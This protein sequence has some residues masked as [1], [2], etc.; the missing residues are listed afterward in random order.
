MTR[1]TEEIAAEQAGAAEG[2]ELTW[3][4]RKKA[5]MNRAEKLAAAFLE[6]LKDGQLIG[7]F[8]KAGAQLQV[9]AAVHEEYEEALTVY[10]QDPLNKEK[11]KRAEELEQ[12]CAETHDYQTLKE[13]GVD[14]QIKYLKALDFVDT[15]G[16]SMRVYN[17][18]R[19]RTGWNDELGVACSCG[20][21]YPNKMWHQ[22]DKNK[23]QWYCRVDWEPLVKEF[24]KHPEDVMLNKL[25]TYLKG[26]YG[27]DRAEW[28]QVGCGARFTPFKKGA[29]MVVEIK[30]A[31]N[32]WTSFVAER[33]PSELDDA[34]KGHRAKFY[35]AQKDLTPEELLDTLPM[36]FPMTHTI[37]EFPGVAQYPVD[38]WERNG[39]PR[40]TVKSWCKLCMKVAAKDL[41]NLSKVFEIAQACEARAPAE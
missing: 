19:A 4:K 27:E 20:L 31:D 18:C 11:K 23:W 35:M 3:S 8:E 36:A 1:A 29:S 15:L 34:I 32:E 2:E 22:P 10:L 16:P 17:V 7:V 37:P 40:M 33:I 39:A 14:M 6:A 26:K 24:E 30:Q 13:K 5:V 38:A 28:P 41:E 21:A 9:S 25:V 12:Q